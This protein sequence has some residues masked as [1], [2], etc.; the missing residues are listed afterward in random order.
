MVNPAQERPR[1]LTGP[2]IGEIA[3][4]TWPKMREAPAKARGCDGPHATLGARAPEPSMPLP[5]AAHKKG[6]SQSRGQSNGDRSR[7]IVGASGGGV[8]P[9]GAGRVAPT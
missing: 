3:A 9:A 4:S 8:N 2:V 5:G 1:R 7:F 6:P